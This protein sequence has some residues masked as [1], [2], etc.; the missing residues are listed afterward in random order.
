MLRNLWDPK[1]THSKHKPTLI[2]VTPNIANVGGIGTFD[3]IGENFT[4]NT[5]AYLDERSLDTKFES[6]SYISG[7]TDPST[8]TTPGI[9]NAYVRT[10]P[11]MKS[12]SVD[13]EVIPARKRPVMTP[14][15]MAVPTVT[16]L[17]PNSSRVN[18]PDFTLTVVGTEF[19]PNSVILFNNEEKETTYVSL[20]EVT[21][22]ISPFT[23]TGSFNAPVC[24]KNG[25]LVSNSVVFRFIAPV[26]PFS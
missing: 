10:P 6:P 22:D 13:F 2:Q 21:T 5:V 26:S 17:S 12:N 14:A 23:A 15:S 20:T 3:F 11:R 7:T 18:G 19:H 16:S 1:G 8:L 9:V 24:V 25:N 4:D